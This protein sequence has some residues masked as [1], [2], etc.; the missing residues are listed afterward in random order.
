MDDKELSGMNGISKC[1]YWGQIKSEVPC[2]LWHRR[3]LGVIEGMGTY[4]WDGNQA[5]YTSHFV[6]GKR[7]G[8]GT[9]RYPYY[10]VHEEH[11]YNIQEERPFYVGDWKED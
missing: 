1:H 7:D 9:M 10:S 8:Y 2:S 5:Q 4:N 6:S 11:V 3:D